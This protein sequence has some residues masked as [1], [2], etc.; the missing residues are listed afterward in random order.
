M[1]SRH[2]AP[3]PELQTLR[4]RDRCARTNRWALAVALLNVML[5]SGCAAWRPPPPGS[6]ENP[7]FVPAGDYEFVWNNVVDVV[8]DYFE[9]ER[10]ARGRVV[11][12][13]MTVGRIDTFPVPGANL[14]EPWH[15]DS[16]T[17][18]DRLES[19]L[20]S[21]RRRALVQVIPTGGG[22]LID[23]AVFKELEDV[24]RPDFSPTSSATIRF[25]TSNQ[26][27]PPPVEAQTAPIGWIPQGRDC[28][29]EQRM[30]G[31]LIERLRP[32]P[33]RG[34]PWKN[35]GVL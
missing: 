31:K 7:L 19:T 1:P 27:L 29:L 25:D 21:I 6:C 28:F 18:Y 4:C 13:V 11:G 15:G 33:A 26:R 23:V 32:S 34:W 3:A 17:P 5:A 24:A 12:N 14:L 35:P 20:Q 30:I 8:D 16:A 22:Y 9:I 10:E 2:R